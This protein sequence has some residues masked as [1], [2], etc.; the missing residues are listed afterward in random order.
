MLK[1]HRLA[2]FA[3]TEVSRCFLASVAHALPIT[4]PSRDVACVVASVAVHDPGA[5]GSATVLVNKKKTDNRNSLGA[6][7]IRDSNYKTE[8]Q[9][10]WSH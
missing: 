6:S 2:S 8:R 3:T 5:V 10:P 7:V 1:A 4:G 9:R